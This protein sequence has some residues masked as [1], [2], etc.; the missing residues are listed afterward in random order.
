MCALKNQISIDVGIG[1]V[2]ATT[3]ATATIYE[4]I[5]LHATTWHYCVLLL[6]PSISMLLPSTIALHYGMLLL[7]LRPTDC[8]ALLDPCP[9]FDCEV[10]A[11]DSAD[12]IDQGHLPPEEGEGVL[13]R[14]Q[15]LLQTRTAGAF[16]KRLVRKTKKENNETQH[17]LA[18][19]SSP[20]KAYE[21]THTPRTP[22]LV[23]PPGWLPL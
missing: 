2:I 10:P 12:G 21:I 5:L 17:N 11:G 22:H 4:W 23:A 16:A 20:E 8:L 3:E 6:L 1:L 14:T 7:A 9:C 19:H 18:G 15:K 13:R